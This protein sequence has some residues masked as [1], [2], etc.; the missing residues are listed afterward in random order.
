MALTM[1]FRTEVTL[2]PSPLRLTPRSRVACL[3]SCFADHIGRHMANSLPTG[4]VAVNPYGSLYNPASIAGALTDL[5]NPPADRAAERLCLL[6][7]ADGLWRHW[8][9]S[10]RLTAP[11]PDELLAE[12]GRRREAVRSLYPALDALVVTFS[13]DQVYRLTE[14]P[15]AGLAVANCH[16]QPARLFSRETLPAEGELTAWRKLL[17]K[18]HE[19]CPHARV[20]FTLSPYRYAGDGLHESQ[21]SKARLLLLIDA[22]LSEPLTD[23]F[24][25]YEI[26]IDELRDYRFYEPDMLHPSAQAIDFV[27][28]RFR[29][30]AFT[31][32]LTSYAAERSALLRDLAH[33][34][35]HPD[36]EAYRRFR[37]NVEARRKA[38]EAKWNEKVGD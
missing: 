3:G 24:P 29:S 21:L 34:P 4:H 11:T 25:A 10:H 9:Y 8:R 37:E 18:F 27:W 23:Y 19:A 33:R 2:P 17:T 14:G 30:W 26:V 16:K 13:T 36:S 15:L 6:E 5:L 32:E 7:G 22:L 31:P 38:F 1:K 12:V 20:I 35:V 28:E